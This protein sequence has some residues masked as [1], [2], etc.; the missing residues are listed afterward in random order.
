MSDSIFNDNQSKFHTNCIYFLGT[1][2]S[3]LNS[4]FKNN[5]GAFDYIDYHPPV[6]LKSQSVVKFHNQNAGAIF[7]VAKNIEISNCWFFN[8]S[9]KIGG[10]I[11]LRKNPNTLR[12]ESQTLL[13]ENVIFEKNIA[14]ETGI[15]TL[16]CD[17]EY[18]YGNISESKFLENFSYYGIF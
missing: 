5:N 10:A 12:M 16:D 8:N 14:G 15:V 2:L 1:T 11:Y 7:T 3:V 6:L 4:I 18:I 9:N 13:I 17:I